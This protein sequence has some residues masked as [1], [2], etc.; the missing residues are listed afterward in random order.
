MSAAAPLS[1]GVVGGGIGGATAA[2]FLR[3]AGV[4]VTVFEQADE[5]REIGAGVQL[6]P[7]A[8]RL[9]ERA[10]IAERLAQFAVTPDIIWQFRKWRTGEVIFEQELTD[11]DRAAWGAPY[12][13]V[14][15]A[16]LLAEIC[17]GLPTGTIRLRARC[18]GLERLP[19]GRV[20]LVFDG[21]AERPAFDA[22]IIADGIQSTLRAKTFGFAPPLFSGY[23]AFRSVVDR[24]ATPLPA[25]PTAMTVWLGPDRHFVHYPI[26]RG[27]V[28]NLV[29]GV[30]TPSWNHAASWAEATVTEF[31]E[32]FA[33]WHSTVDTL[34]SA[35][36]TTRKYA[37]YHSDPFPTWT[38]GPIALLGDA[39]H[40]MLSFFAQGSAQAIEDAAVLARSLR[41]V[42]RDGVADALSTYAA[43]RRPRVGAIQDNAKSRLHSNHIPDGP[44]QIARDERLA[45]SNQVSENSWVYEHDVEWEFDERRRVRDPGEK[46]PRAHGLLG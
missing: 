16:K 15:R 37:L 22:V 25:H 38:D 41:G 17:R 40:P 27:E 33:G 24:A 31:R 10:G 5:F 26:E 14:H 23:F 21:V 1:V 43:I 29:C 8:V 9:L 39:A 20:Q 46:I 34:I 44:E 2:R 32:A 28:V 4:D 30:P 7:N 6:S 13:L 35:A 3:Q 18:T 45:S 36:V 11:A 42:P 19:D 12:L